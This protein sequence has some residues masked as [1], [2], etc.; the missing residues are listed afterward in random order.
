MQSPALPLNTGRRLRRPL[1]EV[2][3]SAQVPKE[4]LHGKNL[5][6]VVVGEDVFDASSAIRVLRLPLRSA[7]ARLAR[8]RL[9]LV[10]FAL[11]LRRRRA[12]PPAGELVALAAD[13]R[14]PL[15][16]DVRF[17]AAARAASPSRDFS[18]IPFW[19]QEPL[20]SCSSSF[21]ASSCQVDQAS[22]RRRRA[23]FAGVTPPILKF[24][25]CIALQPK[26]LRSA[27]NDGM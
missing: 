7:A 26:R 25:L 3:Y 12:P 19:S 20:W 24:Q 22:Q 6:A 11:E 4:L 9:Q 13:G 21:W 2:L 23:P 27:T 17:T 18:H 10:L 5:I 1:R 14:E 16:G 8:P 15:R